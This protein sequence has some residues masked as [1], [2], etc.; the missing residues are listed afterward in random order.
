MKKERKE[1]HFIQKPTYRGGHAALKQFIASEL[2]YPKEAIENKTE[3]TVFLRYDINY[4][5]DV[6]DVHILSSLSK[7]C[8]EEATRLVRLLKFEVPK[9]RK[10]KVLFHKKI[11]IHFKLPKAKPAPKPKPATTQYQY[12][13]VPSKKTELSS[14]TKKSGYSYTIR[15]NKD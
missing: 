15:I 3:G 1:K 4:K 5:G 13:T 12:T 9:T 2:K 11:Q 7:P 14:N 6:V 10:V 8:D